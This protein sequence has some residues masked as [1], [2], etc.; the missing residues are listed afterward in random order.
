MRESY[1]DDYFQ[2]LKSLVG[3]V[4]EGKSYLIL[5]RMLHN[6]EFYWVVPL[7]ENRAED[8]KA[9]R[10][11]YSRQF[12]E[13]EN[14]IMEALIGPCSMLEFLIGMAERM[15]DDLWN[16]RNRTDKWF[17]ELICNVKF[18]KMDDENFDIMGGATYFDVKIDKIARKNYSKTGNAQLFPSFKTSKSRHLRE[19]WVEMT[20]YLNEKYPI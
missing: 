15:D 18:D 17:W 14:D 19:F 3:D 12:P 11:A 13:E 9:L 8:G 6:R 16:G 10:I 20:D 2:W 5:L 7:D 1:R 4:H